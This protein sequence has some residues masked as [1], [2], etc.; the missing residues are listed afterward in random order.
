MRTALAAGRVEEAAALLGRPHQV[1]GMVVAG[2]RRG[3]PSSGFRPPTS[4]SPTGSACPAAG[5]Y[6]AWYERPDGRAPPGG[7]L[8]GPTPHLLRE[9]RATLLVEAYLLDF[10]GDL[11]GEEARVS[12]VARLRDEVAFDSVDALVE[13]MGRDVEV[14]RT[15]LAASP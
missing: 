10:S 3:G 2:D 15:T 7:R 9:R 1:R 4:T 5:I 13:Q 12:F 14:T 8:G 11:Y 6:A